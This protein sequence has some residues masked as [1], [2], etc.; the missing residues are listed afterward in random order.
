MKIAFLIPTLGAGGA[1]RVV[2]LMANFWA[3][4]EHQVTIFSMDNPDNPPFFPLSEQVAYNPMNTLDSKAGKLWRT[5]NQV[6]TLRR[7][8]QEYQP[9]VLIAHLDIAIFLGLVV[10]QLTRRKIIIYEGTNPYLSKTNRYIKAANKAMYRFSDHIVLQTHQVA[11]TFSQYLQPKISVIY[12]P[13]LRPDTRLQNEDY[14]FNLMQKKIVSI[15]RL[16]PPKGY[17]VLLTAF[18]KFLKKQPGWS[19]IILGEGE[20]RHRLETMSSTLGISKRVCFKGRVSDPSSVARTCSIYVLSS[21]YEGLPNALCEAMA[22][23]L[24]VVATRCNF[25]PEEIV[26][27]MVNG[28]L[29]PVGDALELCSALQQLANS[30]TLCERLGTQAKNILETCSIDT[31]MAQWEVVIRQV[32]GLEL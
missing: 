29:V 10:K 7:N 28:L 1:E 12:N 14:A 9:D 4:R 16:V 19:L 2:T 13:V 18:E 8:L 23:G 15:G 27:H 24:P 5:Y 22:I 30:T 6:S 26:Q 31:I 25:G 11:K 32:T 17:E 21:H 20:E 3:K